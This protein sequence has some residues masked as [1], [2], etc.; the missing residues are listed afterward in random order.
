MSEHKHL[1][2]EQLA[3]SLRNLTSKSTIEKDK[4][5]LKSINFL[6]FL[7][8]PPLTFFSIDQKTGKLS[9]QYN[10]CLSKYNERLEYILNDL[11]LL[12][13]YPIKPLI[14]QVIIIMKL[15]FKNN[16][17]FNF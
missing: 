9:Q 11:E 7:P 6:P 2:L 1:T 12:L 13:K 10:E 15:Y 16:I 3:K 17:H 8:P 4:T 5:N 14:N